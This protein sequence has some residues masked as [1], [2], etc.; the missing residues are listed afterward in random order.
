MQRGISLLVA[1]QHVLYVEPHASGQKQ[2][3][4]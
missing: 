3:Q 1:D 4:C 2:G